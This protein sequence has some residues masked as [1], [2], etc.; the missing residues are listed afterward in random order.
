MAFL[1]WRGTRAQ[2]LATVYQDGRSRQ[3]VL[4]TL[5]GA[6]AVPRTIR[7]RVD[8]AFPHLRVDWA[9]IDR[10]LAAGPSGSTPLTA[11]Q[12]TWESAAHALRDWAR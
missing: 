1:R 8:T 2:L 9:A 4:A 3:V 11:E 10:A 7:A 5:G 12:W 6:Y